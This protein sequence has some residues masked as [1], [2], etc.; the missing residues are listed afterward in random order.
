M[1]PAIWGTCAIVIVYAAFRSRHD[2]RALHIGRVGVGV[3]FVAAGAAVNA[4]FLWRGD[5]YRAFADGAYVPFVRDTWRTLVV[6]DH[7][8]FIGLL[9]A[10]E[11]GVGVLALLGG[12]RTQLAYVAAV[13]FHIALLSFGWVFYLWSIP[14]IVALTTLLRGERSGAAEVVPLPD[15]RARVA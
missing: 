5:D 1:L 11:L 7:D 4:F 13:A 9:I 6:P 15:R 12:R 3:L 8:L 2:P 10:F 14:M